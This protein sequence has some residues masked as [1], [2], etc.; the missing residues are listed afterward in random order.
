MQDIIQ[1][2][3][4]KLEK[5]RKEIHQFPEVS[6]NEYATAKRIEKYL[7]KYCKGEI[8]RIADTGV[9]LLFT[10]S[11]NDLSEICETSINKPK[12]FISFTTFFNH[13]L[14]RLLQAIDCKGY[15][16]PVERTA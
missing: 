3:L 12:S 13:L 6:L 15:L 4:P 10:T 8:I 1:K 5:I 16:V 11:K 2:S 9:L 7:K 14:K